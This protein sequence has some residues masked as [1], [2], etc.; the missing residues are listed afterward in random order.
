[1]PVLTAIVCG[2]GPAMPHVFHHKQVKIAASGEPGTRV[3]WKFSLKRTW[4]LRDG[5]EQV[6]KADKKRKLV[7]G[8]Q[9]IDEFFKS[10]K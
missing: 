10:A 1:M 3:A 7:A 2:I 4:E 5:G 8:Q 6:R 9:P